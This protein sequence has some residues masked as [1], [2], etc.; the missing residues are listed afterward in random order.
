MKTL[1]TKNIS[2]TNIMSRS[3]VLLSHKKLSWMK[4]K[5]LMSH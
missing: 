3:L 2:P 4:E 1:V 5:I